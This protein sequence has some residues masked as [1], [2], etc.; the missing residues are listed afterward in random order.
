[1]LRVTA[2]PLGEKYRN[3][4]GVSRSGKPLS[5]APIKKSKQV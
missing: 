1:M 4:K 3:P 5:T 2:T